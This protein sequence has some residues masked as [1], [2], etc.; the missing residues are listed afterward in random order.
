MIQTITY[1]RLYNL[2]NYENERIEVTVSVEDDDLIAAHQKAVS[3]VQ[4]IHDDLLDARRPKK[5]SNQPKDDDI[6]F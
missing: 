3:A 4:Q 2:G 6:P 1:A 5:Y